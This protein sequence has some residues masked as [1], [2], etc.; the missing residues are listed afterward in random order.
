MSLERGQSNPVLCSCHHNNNPSHLLD[1]KRGGG[2]KKMPVSPALM[3]DFPPFFS[4]IVSFV[5]V[6]N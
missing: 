3:T 6:V 1:A 2:I 4:N 5:S